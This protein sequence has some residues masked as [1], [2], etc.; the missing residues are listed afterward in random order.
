MKATYVRSQ[1]VRQLGGWVDS[2]KKDIG[3]GVTSFLTQ[4]ASIENSSDIW[5][6]IPSDGIKRT[7]G[8]ID[9]DR[10][11]T[12]GCYSSDR[13]LTLEAGGQILSIVPLSALCP[14]VDYTDT[15]SITGCSRVARLV[16]MIKVVEVSVYLR[17]SLSSFG[18][19]CLVRGDEIGEIGVRST[20]TACKG[21]WV[22]GWR[23]TESTRGR[24]AVEF[25]R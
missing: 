1:S 20:E 7:T 8:A 12:S 16:G 19:H 11:V 18:L 6:I 3:Y 10:I 9:D 23:E 17:T 25:D 13:L 15:P 14:K 21:A 24:E 4:T 22:G 5:M 2:P